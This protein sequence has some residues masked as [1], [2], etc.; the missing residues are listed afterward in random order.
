MKPCPVMPSTLISQMAYCAVAIAKGRCNIG[1][2]DRWPSSEVTTMRRMENYYKHDFITRNEFTNMNLLRARINLRITS[3]SESG[4]YKKPL[5][6]S[7]YDY[8]SSALPEGQWRSQ[9]PWNVRRRVEDN[10]E[11]E[12][13][14]WIYL[15][16]TSGVLKSVVSIHIV[17]C[18]IACLLLKVFI[19]VLLIVVIAF[20]LLVFTSCLY[21]FLKMMISGACVFLPADI[22]QCHW[23][24]VASCS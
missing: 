17:Y 21:A 3:A 24:A 4:R 8:L 23:L 10:N 14:R 20:L 16:P 6:R 7:D 18:L 15:E 22:P 1:Q 13:W 5:W 19:Q 2:S 12:G 11:E 9:T